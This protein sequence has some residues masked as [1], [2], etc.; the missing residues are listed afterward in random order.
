M[1]WLFATLFGKSTDFSIEGTHFIGQERLIKAKVLVSHLENIVDSSVPKNGTIIIII[2]IIITSTILSF[3]ILYLHYL[4]LLI[5][6][7]CGHLDECL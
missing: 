3:V 5:L 4:N 2:I 1:T 7:K 6:A